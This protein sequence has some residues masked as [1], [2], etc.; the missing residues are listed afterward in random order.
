MGLEFN[1]EF[2]IDINVPEP[3]EGLAELLLSEDMRG[4]VAEI[5][6]YGEDLYQAQVAKDSGD[7]ARSAT[8]FTEIGGEH[9]DRHVGVI[10]VGGRGVDY[11]ASHEFGTNAEVEG[12]A[13]P[14]EETVVTGGHHA[15]HDL[16]V[17][18]QQLGS[19]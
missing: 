10:L 17:V 6:G 7:L 3:N 1:S 5:A 8:S 4:F 12:P 18:G 14:G 9:R 13:E 2:D 19:L 16:D 11:A 15:A